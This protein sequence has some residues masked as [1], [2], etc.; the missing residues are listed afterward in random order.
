M[1]GIRGLH[2]GPWEWVEDFYNE[3]TFADPVPPRSGSEHVLKG[4][5]VFGDVKNFTWSTHGGGPGN[6]FDNGFRLVR[7]VPR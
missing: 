6:G 4:A 1:Y 7:E 2:D 5:S 3:K